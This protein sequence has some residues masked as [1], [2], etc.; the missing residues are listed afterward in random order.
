M[1][2]QI[3]SGL[4][5]K[6]IPKIK[7]TPK[8]CLG[9]DIGTSIIKIAALSKSGPKV[10]LDNYGEI[11]VGAFY[12]KSFRTFEKN[13]LSLSTTDI[14]KA[15]QVILM[16]AKIGTHSAVFSIPDFSTFF[17]NFELPP[18][19]KKELPDAVRYEAPQHIP[20]PLSEITI[21]WQVVGGELIDKKNTKLKILLV[22]VP[23]GI[24]DQYNEITK[25]TNLK[26]EGLEAEVFSLSRLITIEEKK[27]IGLVDIGAQSTTI[28]I[29]DEGILKLSHSFDVAGNEL[30][31]VLVNGLG[32]DFQTAEELKKKYGL[33]KTL[34]N[35]GQKVA[36]L[37]SPQIG[38]ILAEIEK[39]SND[40]LKLE[41]KNIEKIILAGGSVLLP[42]L[43]EHFN[44]VL[45]KD[46]EIINPFTSFILPPILESKLKEMGPSYA[47]ALGAAVRGLLR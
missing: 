24:I 20:L 32:V 4:F 43:R 37:L 31:Q 46:I 7:V 44:S 47:I 30:T 17:T 6:I 10:K 3:P 11:S 41:K 35:E 34:E 23:N 42:G 13:T 9:I 33:K 29:I 12:D 14:A 36:E 19:A 21:D 1:R 8:N 15:I 40:F 25:L 39:I 2:L 22:A 45:K 18:M 5:S 26:L 16:E 27:T 38:L 28:S